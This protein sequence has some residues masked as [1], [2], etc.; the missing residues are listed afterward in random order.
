MGL[1]LEGLRV[2]Y[3]EEGARIDDR[4]AGALAARLYADVMAACAGDDD[5]G[6]RRGALRMAL[7]QLR[8]DLQAAP[9]ADQGKRLA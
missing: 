3:R 4:N 7:Q 8:R 9:S 6:A 5:P 1:A 2:A